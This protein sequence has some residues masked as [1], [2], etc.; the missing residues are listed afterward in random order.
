[1]GESAGRVALEKGSLRWGG[2]AQVIFVVDSRWRR[3][4]G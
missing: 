4:H 3:E 1:M 2:A